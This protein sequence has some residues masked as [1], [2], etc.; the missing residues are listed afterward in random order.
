MTIDSISK[1]TFRRFLLGQQGL[2]P[3]R[4][5]EGPLSTES[6]LLQ[7]QALQ[8]DPLT[9]VARSQDIALYGRVLNYKPGH[10]YQMA[11]QQRKAFDYGGWLMMYPMR[12]FPYW[13]LHMKNRKAQGLHYESFTH[14][15]KELLKFVLNELRDRGPLGNRDFEG[16]KVKAWS[17]RGRKETSIALFYLW[18][19]GEVMI[20][21]RKGFDRIYDLRERVVPSEFDYS[22]TKKE[23]V[24]FMSTKI[25]SF[26]G[27]MGENR[28]HSELSYYIHEEVSRE[29]ARKITERLIQRG[30]VSRVRVEGS[31]DG[32]L[33]LNSD[34]PHLSEL[35][36]GRVPKTWQPLESSTAEEVT[37]L[38]PLEIVSARGR[39]K[40]VFD[41]EYLWEVYKPVHQRRWGY[42]TLPILYGDDLVARLDPKLDRKTNTL[43]IL[44][45]W[46]EE[47]APKDEAF[48]SALA[49]GLKRFAVMIDAKKIDL[50]GI[51]PLKLRSYVK[52]KIKL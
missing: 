5:F 28:V 12:E 19:I 20:S 48:A 10:L 13:G 27:M 21:N 34:Q 26:L 35:D 36:A 47:D 4:R 9:M 11:Y 18:M 51:T 50:S 3:G 24:E 1:L 44:G 49:A 15:P 41:F 22:V 33:F 30:I 37:L 16:A 2:W 40:K 25:I 32:Y 42:Y 31:K 6:A 14:P 46:L 17:Y 38:A 52:K 45:F 43:H 39:S 8:L 29:D 23:A 7:M